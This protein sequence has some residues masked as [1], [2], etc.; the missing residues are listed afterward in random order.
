MTL[1]MSNFKYL[2]RIFY[3]SSGTFGV[4]F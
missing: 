3:F 2:T 1:V 4:D